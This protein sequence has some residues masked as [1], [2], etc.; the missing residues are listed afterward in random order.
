VPT[1]HRPLR[2]NLRFRPTLQLLEDRTTPAT[3]AGLGSA[4]AFAVLDVN[5]GQ[6]S[7]T[8]SSIVGNV[9][10]GT[11]TSGVVRGTNVTGT[12]DVAHTASARFR[13]DFVTGGKAAE[14]MTQ[15]QDD[16][17]AASTAYAALTPTQTFG[18]LKA[19]QTI[20]GN[21]GTNVISVT[22]VDFTNKTLTLK[23]GAKDVFVINVTHDF[24][25]NN[26]KIVL[27][28]GVTANHVVFNFSHAAST[29]DI[30][31]SANVSG[32]FL[33][34]HGSLTLD[35]SASFNGELI[36]KNVDVHA[37]AKLT[38]TAFSVSSTGGAGAS[39]SGFVYFDMDFSGTR[40]SG[41][42]GVS[43]ITITLTGTDSTGKKVTLTTVTGTDGSYA[44]TGLAAGT[45]T[46]TGGALTSGESNG[47]NAVGTVGGQTDG[48]LVAPS[49][50]GSIV[51]AAGNSG[52]EYDFGTLPPGA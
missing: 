44:F 45:Y 50:I 39:L 4:G 16:A 25:F 3:L 2:R 35:S 34:P 29:V 48:T 33:D 12:I 47:T 49:S 31:N 15:V 8:G 9:G 51:L 43:N 26:S 27:T 20:T 42:S 7:I 19:S 38:A 6:F 10:L 24:D 32:T 40:D 1:A 41:E 28:G 22:S 37:D 52:V 5:G 36:A 14:V 30:T 13:N 17:N 11:N 21:G 23:G 18:N 46:L